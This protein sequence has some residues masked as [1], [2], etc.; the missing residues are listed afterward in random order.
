[1]ENLCPTYKKTFNKLYRLKKKKVIYDVWTYN[2][3]VYA[4]YSNDSKERPTKFRNIEQV[5]SFLQDSNSSNSESNQSS[6]SDNE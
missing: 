6:S 1:M 3:V 2:G 4:K 5:D